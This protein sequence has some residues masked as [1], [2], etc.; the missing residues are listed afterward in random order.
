MDVHLYLSCYYVSHLSLWVF[1]YLETGYYYLNMIIVMMEVFSM[2]LCTD[3]AFSVCFNNRYLILH[4]CYQFSSV[5]LLSHVQLFATPWT[6]AC[7]ASLSITNF[8]SPHKPMCIE[9]V[10]P[11]SHLIL[12]RPLLLPPNPSQHQGLFQWVNSF[13]EVAKYWSFS[14]SISPSNEHPGDRK[15][16]V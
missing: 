6:A 4:G 8:Q 13:H 14:L 10:M 1:T 2:S 3:V 11:S 16:V 15:S 9:S 12:G 5:Q 7:Q